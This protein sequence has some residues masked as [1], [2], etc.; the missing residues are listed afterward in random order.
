VVDS[1]LLLNVTELEL[2]LIFF[3][4]RI[5]DPSIDASRSGCGLGW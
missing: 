3:L 4:R 5:R 1:L 2:S